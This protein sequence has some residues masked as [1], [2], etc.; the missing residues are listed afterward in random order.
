M[1]IYR[2]I[3]AESQIIIFNGFLKL[4]QVFYDSKLQIHYTI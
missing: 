4:P 3:S 2:F 1:I